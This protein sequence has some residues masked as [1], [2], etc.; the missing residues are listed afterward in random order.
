MK[1]ESYLKH[2]QNVIS[3]ESNKGFMTS[4]H[5]ASKTNAFSQLKESA[6]ITKQIRISNS[7]L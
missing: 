2:R 4:T 7:V 6:T 5:V 1:E 3:T